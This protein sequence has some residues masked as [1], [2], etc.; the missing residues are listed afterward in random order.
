MCAFA[1][2]LPLLS[3]LLLPGLLV[4]SAWNGNLSIRYRSGTPANLPSVPILAPPAGGVQVGASG[5]KGGSSASI[6]AVDID[7]DGW[8]D[9][10][11]FQ[12]GRM[13]AVVMLTSPLLP[14]HSRWNEQIL[15]HTGSS[16]DML[17]RVYAHFSVPSSSTKLESSASATPSQ[18]RSR[19]PSYRNHVRPTAKSAAARELSG[20]MPTF[21]TSKLWTASSS[22][23][24]VLPVDL[25]SDGRKDLVVAQE[26]GS[27]YCFLLSSSSNRTFDSGNL[28]ISSN[29]RFMSLGDVDGDGIPDIAAADG[30]SNVA[31][32][33]TPT[34]YPSNT[35][36]GVTVDTS[37]AMSQGTAVGDIDGDSIPDLVV[38]CKSA[39]PLSRCL[40]EITWRP[41]GFFAGQFWLT[42]W[43]CCCSVPVRFGRGPLV[44]EYATTNGDATANVRLKKSHP[45]L[46][47]VPLLLLR[48]RWG[49][50]QFRLSF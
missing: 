11:T 32:Y 17:G 28:C 49:P 43:L 6:T 4:A 3:L 7:G 26:S 15:S 34:G 25:N 24:T 41:S 48:C 5:T 2:F 10:R 30:R 18:K 8:M 23:W 35:F 16:S 14:L 47:I 50:E 45:G 31:V 37:Y 9:V 29:I 22:V 36:T 1:C 27:G 21:S 12:I 38:C 46:D 19:T 39:G 44:P 13:L 33:L 20:A 40:A 42:R